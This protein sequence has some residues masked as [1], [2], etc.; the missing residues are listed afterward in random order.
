MRNSILYPRRDIAIQAG[1]IAV[2]LVVF[3]MGAA[4]ILLKPPKNDAEKQVE[5]QIQLK[6]LELPKPQQGAV[7]WMD[8]Q[9]GRVGV[10]GRYSLGPDGGSMN[11]RVPESTLQ[12][13]TPVTALYWPAKA[14]SYLPHMNFL[15]DS[16]LRKRLDTRMSSIID[17]PAIQKKSDHAGRL[18]I[19][20][21]SERIEPQILALA[22]DPELRAALIRT[23]IDVAILKLPEIINKFRPREPDAPS[24]Q[25]SDRPDWWPEDMD[26]WSPPTVEWQDLLDVVRRNLDQWDWKQ[27]SGNIRRDPKFQEAMDALIQ[28]M[29]P[30][31]KLAL[32]EILWQPPVHEGN[33]IPNARLV[34][35]GRRL[36][37]GGRTSDMLLY[38]DSAGQPIANGGTIS[39]REA[40]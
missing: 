12:S 30:H 2:G 21:L 15:F 7:Y 39:G 34:W 20:L 18:L 13:G 40:R 27:W 32:D 4:Y 38:E 6:G 35:V 29:E 26:D 28:E 9:S 22:T 23:G 19:G 17:N 31:L 11:L 16:D 5:I 3:L 24:P 1:I 33:D 37:L 25:P 36:L 8:Q 10:V 14:R